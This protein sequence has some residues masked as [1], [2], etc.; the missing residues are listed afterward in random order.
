MLINLAVER[1]FSG[2]NDDSDDDPDVDADNQSEASSSALEKL[3]RLDEELVS[4]V[5][6]LSED[7]SFTATPYSGTRGD[8]GFAPPH[9]EPAYP[10]W[11]GPPPPPPSDL[12]YAAPLHYYAYPPME[13][14][15]V[16]A[17]WLRPSVRSPTSRYPPPSEVTPTKYTK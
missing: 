12:R 17:R 15:S 1:L 4:E 11:G 2:P 10:T 5:S 14:P 9:M 16:A 3:E 8:W 6:E 7:L 13:P